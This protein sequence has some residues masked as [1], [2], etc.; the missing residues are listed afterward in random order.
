M[1]GALEPHATHSAEQSMNPLSKR[2]FRRRRR[3]RRKDEGLP[4]HKGAAKPPLLLWRCP[5]LL[6]RHAAKC[7]QTRR[8]LRG[9]RSRLKHC[10]RGSES[11]NKRPLPGIMR[12][13]CQHV[14][15]TP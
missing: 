13:G 14:Q 6:R 8:A 15:V 1:G 10:H 11:L 12:P 9:R 5:L 7:R 2:T 3:Q 4:K